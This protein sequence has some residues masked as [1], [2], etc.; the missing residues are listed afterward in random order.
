MSFLD[1]A[2]ELVEWHKL[3]GTDD[4]EGTIRAHITGGTAP[5]RT[6][7]ENGDIVQGLDVPARWRLCSAMP[8]TIRVL[9]A[10]GQDIHKGI[11]V[12]EVGCP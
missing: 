6:Q 4:W 8:A 11:W 9:S 5:Y 10:D 7:L 3:A 2:W 12:Y 1:P